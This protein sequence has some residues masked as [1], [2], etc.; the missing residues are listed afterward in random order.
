L[1]AQPLAEH[2]VRT[3]QFDIA[4]GKI[5]DMA[6]SQVYSVL[7]PWEYTDF[8][9]LRVAYPDLNVFSVYV[10]S[11]NDVSEDRTA[12]WKS[13]QD[14]FYGERVLHNLDDTKTL[15]GIK[16]YVGFGYTFPIENLKHVL[17]ALPD[18]GLLQIILD[19]LNSISPLI[20]YETSWMW[21]NPNVDLQLLDEIGHYKI[22]RV[23]VPSGF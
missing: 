2:E 15:G 8:H 17:E 6:G 18:W 7:L 4:L 11:N 21:N 13:F 22:F 10:Y 20:H 3:G 23:D 19:K 14:K 16:Y 1:I 5:Q 9:Y 12:A